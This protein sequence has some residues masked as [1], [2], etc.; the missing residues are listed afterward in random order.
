MT[1]DPAA[2]GPTP[3][4]AQ[5]GNAFTQ[6]WRNPYVRAVVFL[7]L[8]YYA[9]RFIDL[10]S[11]VLTLAIIAYVI[12]YLANPLLKW[13]VRRRIRRGVGVLLVVL[14]IFGAVALASTLLVTVAGQFANLLGQLPE[15]ARSAT[16]WVNGLLER[17]QNVPFVES[18]QEQLSRFTENSAAT[19]SQ[20]ALPFV[21]RLLS[22]GGVVF[23][24]LLS[25][26]SFLGEAVAVLIISIYMMADYDRIGLSLLR[27][28]PRKW[29]PF[30]LQ[31]SQN[32]ERAVGGYLRGQLLI[33]AAV[34]TLIGLGLAIFGIPSALA[35]G[36]LAGVTNIV[37]YLGVIIAVTPALL[38]A[39][40][41]GIWKAVAVI[42]VFVAANQIEGNFLSPYILGRTTDLHPV[43]VV[44]AILGGLALFGI[45]GALLAVPLA[46][47]GKLLL[48]EYYYPSRLYKEGP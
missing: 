37:P 11:H 34:G 23:G 39:L 24:S 4:P 36:F 2:P 43:T 29:Q 48:Q 40:P 38:L 27:T 5:E 21:Q 30:V 19:L 1:T 33:A 31:L 25:F 3:P 9:Y 6:V 20:S 47:L 7:A 8:I 18:L 13:L 35:I 45:V 22:Q 44:L 46:A 12:A 17:Y 42:A 16:A 15:L 14:L 41:L 26:A 10:I 32:V 28:F